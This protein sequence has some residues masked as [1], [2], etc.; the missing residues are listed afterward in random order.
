MAFW[1]R[2]KKSKNIVKK[3]EF[4]I[5]ENC[6]V[7]A[8]GDIHGRLDLLEELCDLIKADSENIDKERKIAVFIGDYVD[9]G[10]DSKGVIDFLLSEPLSGFEHIFIMGNHEYVMQQFLERQCDGNMWLLWGGDATIQSYGIDL[11]KYSGKGKVSKKLQ[12]DFIESFPQSHKEFLSKLKLYHQEGDYLF[13]HAGIRPGV[14][15]E[16]QREEDLMMIRGDFINSDKEMPY[17]IVYG[18]TVTDVPNQQTDKLGID[19]G[20]YAT[21]RLTA[22]VLDGSSVRFLHT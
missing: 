8:I 12:D 2:N 16:K 15:L 5:S 7:Y 14:A 3:Q 9:R 22:A 10:L 17:K 21:G 6:V 18:H 1:N 11:R 13:V 19:T 4:N 20:A